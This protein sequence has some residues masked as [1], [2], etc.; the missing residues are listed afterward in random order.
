MKILIYG[1]TFNPIHYGHINNIEVACQTFDFDKIM[2]IPNKIGHFKSEDDL[3]SW[4]DR[5]AMIELG[6]KDLK[7]V[8]CP[9]E[10][11]KIELEAKKMIY[12]IDVIES[13]KKEY[14]K[15]ELY[16]LIGSDQVAKLDYWRKSEKLKTLVTF[17]VSKRNDRF[18]SSE[19][20]VLNND[21][22]DVSSSLVR[23]YYATTLISSVDAYIREK[24]LYL[25]NVISHYLND[26]RVEHSIN[27]AKMAVKYAKKYH[28]DPDKAY[29]AAMLHDIAKELPMQIQYSLVEDQDNTFEL[30]NNTVHAYAAAGLIKRDLQIEDPEILSAVSKH[31]TAAFDM[32]PLDK[33]IYVS[34][35]LSEGRDFK[36]LAKLRRILN[37]D[38]DE[39][40]R[41]CFLSSMANLRSRKITIDD[42]LSKLEEKIRRK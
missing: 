14:P 37:K 18:K 7:G 15:A 33:L 6:L 27:V 34:D 17:I 11:N 36:G 3:A 40:F 10:I 23:Q 35:M 12:S 24:G 26:E 30:N 42:N 31:T 32:S 22:Y 16:F 1:G 21:V 19:L 38:L 41:E 4:Q 8:S 9:I 5:L 13:I 20:L 28:I 2:V 25:K 29:I 39:A